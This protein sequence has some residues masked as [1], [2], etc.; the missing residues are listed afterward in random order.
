MAAA[1]TAARRATFCWNVSPGTGP[2]ST[3]P[4]YV[5]R[6]MSE[7]SALPVGLCAGAA[8]AGAAAG[9][10][11]GGGCIAFLCAS[12]RRADVEAALAAEEG[13]EVL[14]WKLATEGLT[15]TETTD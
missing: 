15:V 9:V 1:E 11:G 3:T 5:D 2:V 7:R 14:D 6:F 13:A 4:Q 10:A 8:A 12:G